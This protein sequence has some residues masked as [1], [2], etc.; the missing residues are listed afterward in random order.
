MSKIGQLAVSYV[1]MGKSQARKDS[2]VLMSSPVLG[3]ISTA[4]DDRPSQLKA[5]QVY[6]RLALLAAAHGIW[7]QPV[8]QIV[9]LPELKAQ[10]AQLLPEPELAPQH[11]FRIGYAPAEKEHTPRR[12]LED[13]LV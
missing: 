3:I 4:T 12:P 1:D 5:G 13:V 7:C 11:P 9:Q 2:D 6:Q 10:V 8:S